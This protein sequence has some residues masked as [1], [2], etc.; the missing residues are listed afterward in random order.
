MSCTESSSS[1][2]LEAPKWLLAVTVS[3][4]AASSPPAARGIVI[5]SALVT[6]SNRVSLP[7]C[8]NNHKKVN[9]NVLLSIRHVSVGSYKVTER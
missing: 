8:L 3:Q 1:S 7:F 4:R 5:V 9:R 2:D 6:F